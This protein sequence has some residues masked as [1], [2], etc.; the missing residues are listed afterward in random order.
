MSDHDSKYPEITPVF[1]LSAA[2]HAALYESSA[3]YRRIT[4]AQPRTVEV[5]PDFDT[6]MEMPLPDHSALVDDAARY[7][8]DCLGRAGA[9]AEARNARADELIA[10]LDARIARADCGGNLTASVAELREVVHEL[11]G[12]VVLALGRSFKPWTPGDPI[13]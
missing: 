13:P 7:M 12:L 10:R 8:R 5:A 4:L 2:L 3:E 11:R 9:A 1:A 6:L